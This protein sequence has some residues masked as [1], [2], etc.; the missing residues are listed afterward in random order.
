VSAVGDSNPVVSAEGDVGV[1][2]IVAYKVGKA[3]VQAVLA[4]ALPLLRELG[5]TAR[6]EAF[7]AALAE[8][9]VHG[10]TA[11]LARVLAAL[12]TPNHLTLITLALGLDAVLS[13]FE[14]WALHRRFRWAP[15]LVVIAGALLIPLEIVELARH[16]RP[17]RAAILLVNLAIIVYLARRARREHGRHGTR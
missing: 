17:A 8:N 10:W 9:V 1:R 6:L 2:V 5:V 7:A 13:S 14:A 12:L 11:V 4:A 16:A 3:I 15:W